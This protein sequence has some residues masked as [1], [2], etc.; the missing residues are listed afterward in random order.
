MALFIATASVST[1]NTLE[2]IQSKANDILHA[3]LDKGINDWVRKAEAFNPGLTVVDIT[4]TPQYAALFIAVSYR[5][6]APSEVNLQT[7]INRAF[8]DMGE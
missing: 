6:A 4:I 5:N 3:C 2:F 8:T 1:E 7:T